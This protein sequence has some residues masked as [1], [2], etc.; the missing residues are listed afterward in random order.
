MAAGQTGAM[1]ERL[2]GTG[3]AY[4][5]VDETI[6]VDAP[7]TLTYIVPRAGDA[8]VAAILAHESG[9]HLQSLTG[10]NRKLRLRRPKDT[11]TPSSRPTACPAAYIASTVLRGIYT[12]ERRGGHPCP[13]RRHRR[14]EEGVDHGTGEERVDAFNLGYDDGF[15]RLRAVRPERL[16]RAPP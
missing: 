11:F 2:P 3:P 10:W 8:A 12:G 14:F 16:T 9:H 6:L 4:C 5:G 15:R 13:L 7:W 1:L